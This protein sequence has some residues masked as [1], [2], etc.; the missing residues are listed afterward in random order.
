[1]TILPA[2]L[3]ALVVSTIL[4]APLAH[5]IE[6]KKQLTTSQQRMVDCNKQAAGKKGDV[7]KAFLQ[8]CLKLK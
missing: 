6:Q 5:A 8:A 7:R 3:T 4:S 1:M 2:I